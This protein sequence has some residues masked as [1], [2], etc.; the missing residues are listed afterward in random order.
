ML[1]MTHIGLQYNI[2]HLTYALRSV[3]TSQVNITYKLYE[4]QWILVHICLENIIFPL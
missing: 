1:D 2:S 3:S 4:L